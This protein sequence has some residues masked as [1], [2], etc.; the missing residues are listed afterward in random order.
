MHNLFLFNNVSHG[1]NKGTDTFHDCVLNV[2]IGKH[3]QGEKIKKIYVNLSES[4]LWFSKE[5]E[6][7]SF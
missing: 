1:G 7:Y 3:V 6:V 4:I 5:E 2:N